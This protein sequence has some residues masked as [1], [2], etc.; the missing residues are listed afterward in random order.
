MWG[1]LRLVVLLL[2]QLLFGVGV[3]VGCC[4]WRYWSASLK[5]PTQATLYVY[6]YLYRFSIWLPRANEP[7]SENTQFYYYCHYYIYIGTYIRYAVHSRVLP[8]LLGIL[9]LPTKTEPAAIDFQCVLFEWVELICSPFTHH[10]A[11]YTRKSHCPHII[12]IRI[13]VVLLWMCVCMS[14]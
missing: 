9:T 14:F 4:C 3:V 5:P 12:I 1:L 11:L 13:H 6:L 7:N 10:T 2:L 8:P